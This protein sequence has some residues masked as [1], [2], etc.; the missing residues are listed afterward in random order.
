MAGTK[1]NRQNRQEK[2]QMKKI[3]LS[4]IAGSALCITAR[5]Q[6]PIYAAQSLITFTNVS[7]TATNIGAVIDCRKQATVTIQW[8][9]GNISGT[10][11][12]TNSIFFQYS[13]DGVTYTPNT[14]TTPGG[15][16]GKR[17]TI[18]A[19]GITPTTIVTNLATLGCGYIKLTFGT[20]SAA[21]GDTTNVLKYAIKINA[22]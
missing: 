5:A 17:V 13:V 22:P 3:L 7:S 6:A 10:G 11:T 2:I 16:T 9:A 14:E 20:N 8:T 18:A 4:I 21:A 15:P 19:T 12:D 1:P